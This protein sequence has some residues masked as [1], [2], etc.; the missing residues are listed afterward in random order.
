M[1]LWQ[2]CFSDWISIQAP[3]TWLKSTETLLFL[4]T[5]LTSRSSSR[6]LDCMLFK[7]RELLY[8]KNKW[9]WIVV[10]LQNQTTMKGG[11]NV[12]NSVFNF[13]SA[14]LC[15]STMNQISPSQ[16]S[17]THVHME[18]C[19]CIT[20]DSTVN[21]AKIGRPE[22]VFITPSVMKETKTPIQTNRGSWWN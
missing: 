6:A 9:P 13:M 15:V 22:N 11:P 18:S 19:P 4:S 2:M 16:E 1:C 10:D 7:E 5:R 3:L 8:M 14:V 17:E 12:Q 20:T 21:Q